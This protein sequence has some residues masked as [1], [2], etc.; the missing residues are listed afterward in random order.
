[1]AQNDPFFNARAA[2]IPQDGPSTFR[3]LNADAQP[4]SS[5]GKASQRGLWANIKTLFGTPKRQAAI[6]AIF[7]GIGGITDFAEMNDRMGV[8]ENTPMDALFVTALVG[9]PT[10][11]MVKRNGYVSAGVLCGIAIMNAVSCYAEVQAGNPY[12]DGGSVVYNLFFL[13]IFAHA[14]WHLW[15]A[16]K[17]KA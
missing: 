7:Y 4:A 9:I 8:P 17:A 16:R 12:Y 3:G 10:A 2:E 14:A 6:S 13:G 15:K 5:T 1:M 11:L